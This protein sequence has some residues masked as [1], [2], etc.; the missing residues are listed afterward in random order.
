M[1]PA[2]PQVEVDLEVSSW[3]EGRGVRHTNWSVR[4]NDAWVPI[5]EL[6]GV[7]STM[8]D[9]DVSF[10]DEVDE[11]VVLPPGCQ[12]RKT[13]HPWLPLGTRVL[14]RVSVPRGDDRSVS[15]VPTSTAD[16]M[17]RVLAAFPPLK[18]PLKTTITEL[19]VG[20]HG[21]LIPEHEWQERLANVPRRRALARSTSLPGGE[22]PVVYPRRMR[23]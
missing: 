21:R 7:T 5:T 13:Y 3:L 20:A 16:T 17:R 6:R 9:A 22:E 23:A 10:H 1:P 11:L 19:R 8:T 14:R 18:R 4:L 15:Q 12:Y 2:L